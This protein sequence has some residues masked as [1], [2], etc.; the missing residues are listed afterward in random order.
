MT[1]AVHAFER[2]RAPAGRL[3][4][5]LGAPLRA[6]QLHILPDAES[7][8][9]VGACPATVILYRS[10][11]RPDAKLMPTLLACDAFRR[12]G[13]KRLVLVAPYM[14]YLR[15]DAVFLPGQPLSR[16]VIGCLLGRAF[17]RIVTVDP[18]LHRTTSLASVFGE[19]E[20]EV[21]T[22][23]SVLAHRFCNTKPTLVV[24]PDAES[25]PWA[26]AVGALL[27]V[28]HLT[29][30]KT[31]SGDREVAVSAPCQAAVSGR[32]VLL[33]DDIC[34]TGETLLDATRRLQMA[35]AASVDI[36]VVHALFKPPVA[37]ALRSAGARSVVSTDS[38]AHP[39]NAIH[40]ASV[41]AATLSQEF[42]A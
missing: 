8:P 7:L 35:G 39:T 40:L 26:A 9:N 25:E 31:R 24:G 11:D 38:C 19:A 1:A 5:A 20:V 3:A 32:R 27:G 33:L 41:L 16:D 21:L 14:P 17:D 36:A 28:A 37:D 42:A 15:Q 4:S 13:A 12:A 2:D 30:S 22:A 34:S 10:L 18:H 23:A 6:V 29:L